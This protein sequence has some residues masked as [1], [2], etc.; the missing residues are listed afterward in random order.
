MRLRRFTKTPDEVKRYGIN[1]VKWLDASEQIDTVTLQV[2]GGDGLLLANKSSV[3]PDAKE[4]VFFVSAGTAGKNYNVIVEISTT[5]G[6]VREDTI[7]FIVLA[8]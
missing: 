7:P 2:T 4:V 5:I 8:P 6:Q 3:S 1:Y